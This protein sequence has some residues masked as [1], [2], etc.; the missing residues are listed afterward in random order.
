[1]GVLGGGNQGGVHGEVA[2]GP[3]IYSL[4]RITSKE[5]KV[6]SVDDGVCIGV[7]CQV[8]EGRET[9]TDVCYTQNA[10]MGG[11]K[12]FCLGINT[13]QGRNYGAGTVHRGGERKNEAWGFKLLPELAVMDV[14]VMNN[15]GRRV[16]TE[17]KVTLNGCSPTVHDQNL[18]T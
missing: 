3:V 1:V 10:A 14:Q 7:S 4:E 2:E 9:V 13:W 16:A 18:S 5:S 6:T 11:I 15:L 17:C 12:Y 8:I